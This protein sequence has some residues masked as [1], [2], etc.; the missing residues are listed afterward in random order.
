MKIEEKLKELGIDLP[1]VGKASGNYLPAK[2]VGNLVFC[3]GNGPRINAG[4]IATGRVGKDL[5]LEEGYEAAK[6]CAINCLSCIKSVIG[7]LDRIDE[8]I[9]VRG[10]VTSAP[11]FTQQPSV[12]NGASDLLI[13][14]FGE[15]G[16][17]ARAA[18]G[19]PT[20]P[21]NIAVEVEMIVK[22]K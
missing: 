17:H 18:L 21:G 22:I 13:K 9:Q 1:E 20:S 11:D 16:R 5:T 6:W 2:V 15:K 12:I 14:L 8:I 19:V 3:S 4:E 10:F 7:S